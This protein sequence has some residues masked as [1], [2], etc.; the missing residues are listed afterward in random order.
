MK[1]NQ[2]L[3]SIPATARSQ[4]P[5]SAILLLPEIASDPG[6]PRKCIASTKQRG[7]VSA[8]ALHVV[9]PAGF[10]SCAA[11]KA[12]SLNSSGPAAKLYANTAANTI[13][14]MTISRLPTSLSYYGLGYH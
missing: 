12:D 6:F 4:P 13:L 10:P 11:T 2:V 9:Q 7:A 14:L 8:R 3:P 5:C 1:R